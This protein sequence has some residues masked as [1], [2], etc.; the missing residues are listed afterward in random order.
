MASLN[1]KRIDMKDFLPDYFSEEDKLEYE[2]LCVDSK[3]YFPECDD[4]VVH[5]C[6]LAH[7]NEKIGRSRPASKED[8]ENE[9]KKHIITSDDLVIHTPYDSDFD[10]NSTLKD[11]RNYDMKVIENNIANKIEDIKEESEDDI[12]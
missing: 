9:R 1:S 3:R 12:Q 11:H 6:V 2:M 10:M 8:I 7:I 5:I 4:Y